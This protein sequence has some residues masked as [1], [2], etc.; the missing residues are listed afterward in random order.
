VIDNAHI[1]EKLTE[2]EKEIDEKMY[3]TR[4]DIQ[5]NLIMPTPK[6]KALLRTHLFSYFI[7]IP[8]SNI[9][10]NMLIEENSENNFNQNDMEN[11]QL[12][13]WVLRIQGKIMPVLESQPGGFFRKFSYFFQKIQIKFDQNNFTK[14]TDIEWNRSSGTDT[15]GFEIKRECKMNE[16]IKLKILFYLNTYTQE[17]KVT[18]ELA[19]L[20]G[21]KQE[22]R[23]KILYH[24]WQYIKINSLQ[25]NDN[26][27]IIINNKEL[28]S[29]FKCDKMDIT[30]LYPKLTDYI[31][32]LD[33]IEIDYEIK[34][35]E[36]WTS[37]QRLFDIVV[38][39]D[40]PHFLDI[41][42]FLS[43]IDNESLLF[44]KNLFFYKNENQQKTDKLQTN[45]EKFYNKLQEIDRNMSDLNEKLK[46]HKYK[47]DFYEAFSKDPVKFVNN[48]L[49]QQNSLLKIMKEESSI[50]DAR[51][52]YNSSNYYKDYEE[53]LREYVDSYLNKSKTDKN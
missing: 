9:D 18:G 22:T 47:H 32:P 25:D 20:I 36:D 21:I 5:E 37:N 11:N 40:D 3:K 49:T 6:V 29:L 8:K 30:S 45:T 41:S 16:T 7:N 10:E 46:K 14:Y 53:I 34:P 42:N 39:V 2:I 51:W 50:I 19:N 52:D 26:P 13:N 4:L 1:Y 33:P 38:N 12:Q 35:V 44:P 48:F 27:N 24:V 15:D 31:R 43:N 17:C 28:R 23:P